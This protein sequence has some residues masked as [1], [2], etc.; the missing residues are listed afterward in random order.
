MDP[1]STAHL[2]PPLPR[3]ETRPPRSRSAA[4]IHP[5]PERP[6]TAARPR[7]QGKFLFVG[8]D[9]FYVRGVTYGTFRPD[10]TGTEFPAPER[11]ERDFALMAENGVNVVRTYTPAPV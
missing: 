10:S 1:A 9:K 8:S 3:P 6:A 4:A 11:V 7:V 2:P 5:A